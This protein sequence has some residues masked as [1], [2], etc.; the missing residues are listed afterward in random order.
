MTTASRRAASD[1][2]TAAHTALSVALAGLLSASAGA[3][4]EVE[5]PPVGTLREHALAEL[6]SAIG[7]ATAATAELR[8]AARE[9]AVTEPPPALGWGTHVRALA[10]AEESAAKTS[11]ALADAADRL[12][13]LVAVLD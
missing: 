2:L 3:L 5:A 11:R 8:I 4:D 1:R 13:A 9:Y 6:G 7:V 12:R 10:W